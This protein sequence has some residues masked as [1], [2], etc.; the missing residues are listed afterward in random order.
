[1]DKKQIDS[2]LAN[3]TLVEARA[4]I[5]NDQRGY[6]ISIAQWLK[7]QFPKFSSK[8]EKAKERSLRELDFKVSR[9]ASTQSE[10][11][12][13]DI[14]NFFRDNCGIDLSIS[15]TATTRADV[16][17]NNIYPAELS[18]ERAESSY[19]Q[20]VLVIDGTAY[21]VGD[22]TPWGIAGG[23]TL[24]PT[25][26]SPEAYELIGRWKRQASIHN[27]GTSIVKPRQHG[28]YNRAFTI[29]A[30]IEAPETE[31]YVEAYNDNGRLVIR[32]VQII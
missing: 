19:G 14:V 24:I 5:T 6:W 17:I 12:K 20:P 25:E 10:D 22:E 8:S 2:I 27:A 23:L 1:M 30:S 15:E 28:Q 31:Y 18:T 21:G 16:L 32:Y 11:I 29:P 7:H 3:W 26:P 13:D 9:I 4:K